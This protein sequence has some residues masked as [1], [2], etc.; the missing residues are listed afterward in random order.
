MVIFLS[1]FKIKNVDSNLTNVEDSLYIH[2]YIDIYEGYHY[3]LQS[4]VDLKLRNL[5]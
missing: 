1:E 4:K 2:V 3:F 5:Q